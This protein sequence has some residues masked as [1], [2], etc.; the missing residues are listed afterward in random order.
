MKANPYPGARPFESA[1]QERFFGRRQEV[2]ILAAQVLARRASLLFAP[3]GA[4]KSLLIHAGLVPELTRGEEVGRGSRRRTVHKMTVLPV[5]SVGGAVPARLER[6]PDNVYVFSALYALFPDADPADLA[7]RRLADAVAPLLDDGLEETDPSDPVPVLLVFDP[8]EELF[9]HNVERW[10]ER[11]PFFEEVVDAIRRHPRLHVLFSM[12]EDFIAELTPFANLLPGGLRD[13]FR[14]ERLRPEAALDAVRRPAAD[15]GRPFAEGVAEELID[16]LRRAQKGRRQDRSPAASGG[17]SRLGEFIEPVHLQIVCRR[18]WDDLDDNGTVIESGDLSRF[19]DVDQALR[20]FYADGL[21]RALERTEVP[22]HRLRAWFE[23]TTLITP[24]R[25]RGLVYRGDETTEGLA[26]AAVDELVDAYL[27]RAV[28][29][30]GD[31]W[32]ELAHD[33]LVEP[34]LAANRRWRAEHLKPVTVAAEAWAASD[35]DPRKLY[36][37]VLLADARREAETRPEAYSELE[38]EFLE[39][40][41]RRKRAVRRRWLKAAAPAGIVLLLASLVLGRQRNLAISRE[42]AAY[43]IGQTDPKHSL[44]LALEAVRRRP[45]VEAETALRQALLAPQVV[46]EW[47]DVGSPPVRERF[48]PDGR[49]LATRDGGELVI[50]DASSGEIRWRGPA[51]RLA[52]SPDGAYVAISAA[53]GI[54]VWGTEGWRRKGEKIGVDSTLLAVGPSGRVAVKTDEDHLEIRD[55]AGAVLI[56]EPLLHQGVGAAL[57]GSGG[58]L[59][60]TRGPEDWILWSLRD[61]TVRQIA[62]GKADDAVFDETETHLVTTSLD[63][64]RVFRVDAEPSLVADCAVGGLSGAAGTRSA[65]VS[66]DGSRFGAAGLDGILRI[67]RSKEGCET[68][69]I[70]IRAHRAPIN[71]IAFSRTGEFLLTASEDRSGAVWTARSG[72][73]IAELRGH[74]E[75]LLEAVWGPEDDL[76]LTS[77]P[78]A[79]RLW[80]VALPQILDFGDSTLRDAILSPDG[81]HLV[82]VTSR[83]EPGSSRVHRTQLME[84]SEGVEVAKLDTGKDPPRAAVFHPD[85]RSVAVAAGNRIYSLGLGG[86]PRPIASH[87]DLVKELDFSAEGRR[88]L[89]AGRDAKARLWAW[90]SGDL[91]RCVP[92]GD[93]TTPAVSPT[94][95]LIATHQKNVTTIWQVNENSLS[96]CTEDRRQGVTLPH[97]AEVEGASFDTSGRQ[98]ATA[99]KDGTVRLW[100]SDGRLTSELAIGGQELYGTALSPDGSSVIVWGRDERV[101]LWRPQE[102]DNQLVEL[103]VHRDSRPAAFSRDGRLALTRDELQGLAWDTRWPDGRQVVE[104]PPESW[105]PVRALSWSA[106]GLQLA[107]AWS[108][109]IEVYECP[110]CRPFDEV[111]ALAQER[112]DVDRPTPQSWRERVFSSR[113]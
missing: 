55:P 64:I 39:A 38:L 60:L 48:S 84:L 66:P 53:A 88:L 93:G 23:D 96:D 41:V 77:T 94:G 32:Y 47:T 68:S 83:R 63:R 5:G 20:G 9:T 110:A 43:S 104:L 100:R 52:W 82:A 92:H 24:A 78:Q 33:R 25:T 80:R 19:G 67:V 76:L 74:R 6:P 13:R 26:N 54:D 111:L 70:A 87:E 46:K 36:S 58:D 73:L 61:G 15:A 40:S 86:P 42:L 37:G 1:D 89:S 97:P 30:G 22:E 56:A 31:V 21:Q 91:L 75:R 2:E 4:G 51:E 103:P 12:R 79:V 95:D 16:N 98:L 49:L 90:P 17:E 35:R 102:P 18:L 34:I 29:R 99:C 62:S 8:F 11:L 113:D 45:T 107:A 69:Q 10:E 65:A 108:D 109:R 3:S 101:Y 7:G 112:Q 59:L 105:E 44:Q 57:F 106:D 85:G 28:R 27:V 72:R 81:Q 50:R 71:S 14:I